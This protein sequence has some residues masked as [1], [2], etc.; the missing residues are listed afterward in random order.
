M[1][2]QQIAAFRAVMMTGTVS[3]AAEILGRSQPAVSR[4]IDRLEAQMGLALFE[5]RKGRVTPTPQAHQLLDEVERAYVSLDSL[6]SF[7]SRLAKGQG[8]QVSLASMP[9]LG[10]SFMPR[11]IASF[12]EAWPE[13]R[14]I[15]NI[16]MSPTVE[17]WA[18]G[19]QVDFGLAEMPVRRSGFETEIFS[20]FPYIAAVP[21]G[22]ELADRSC[23][24]PKDLRKAPLI[25]WTSFVSARHLIDQAL[26]TSG[27]RVDAICETSLSAAAYEMVKQGLGIGIIDPYTAVLQRDERIRLIPFRP[28][29]PFSVALLR[30]EFRG[31][32]PAVEQML[33]VA[34]SVRDG[35]R[36][37]LAD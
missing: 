14:V 11:V 20:D 17:E 7:A 21:E 22:H 30:P 28:A 2:L 4:M 34:R 1:N 10:L 16:R 36:A 3:G 23:L 32:T 27:V 25:Y 5:R 19:Q 13:T 6:Q 9:A 18:A 35:I 12:R 31:A 29:I 37:Q 24:G 33:D 8:D 15:L 26:V